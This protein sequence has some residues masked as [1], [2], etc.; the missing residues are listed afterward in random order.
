MAL[1]GT[2][3]F[4]MN[5]DSLIKASLR[6]TTSYESGESIPAQEIRDASEALNIII[7]SWMIDG[8]HLW[9]RSEITLTLV[10]G[11]RS[12]T[13]GPAG[14]NTSPRP[15]R[16]SEAFIRDGTTDTPLDIISKQEYVELGD[17][18]TQGT[19]NSL[20]F[21]PTLTK[22]TVFVYVAPDS[23]AATNKAIHLW[24]ERQ[25]ADLTAATDDFEFPQ[26]WYRALKWNLANELAPEYGLA[27]LKPKLMAKIERTA[28]KFYLEVRDFDR[29][30]TSTFFTP[31]DRESNR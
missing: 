22:S 28:E 27:D 8:L 3:T 25:V 20:Y 23:N 30:D 1:S 4:S 6:L 16:L 12:Y 7:K 17:K 15:L 31:S 11:Q 2:T 10:A 24:V 5:R 29:E 21:E 9:L 26:E 19:P 18:S 14:D 13:I